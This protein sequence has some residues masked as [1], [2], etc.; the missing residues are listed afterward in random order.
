MRLLIYVIFCC[1]TFPAWAE[2]PSE[3]QPIIIE[4]MDVIHI[5]SLMDQTATTVAK[6]TLKEARKK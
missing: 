5:S 3:K 2:K 4:M 1:F 6:A